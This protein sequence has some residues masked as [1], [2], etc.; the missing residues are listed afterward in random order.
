MIDFEPVTRGYGISSCSFPSRPPSLVTAAFVTETMFLSAVAV[1]MGMRIL[2]TLS[3][4][5]VIEER[6]LLLLLR[7]QI[8]IF[9]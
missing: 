1:D 6:H 8:I 2:K 5:N 4:T 3:F 7:V 9:F